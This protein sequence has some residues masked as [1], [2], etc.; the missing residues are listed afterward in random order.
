MIDERIRHSVKAG[1][2]VLL[3]SVDALGV[4]SCC[5]ALA[6]APSDD[7]ATVTTYDHQA[8]S[9]ET[10]A[11]VAA[12]HRLAIVSTNPLDHCSIQLKGTTTGVRL[13]RDDEEAIA[14]EGL[15][16]FAR[17]LEV[18]GVPRRILR[19]VAHWPAFAIEMRVEEIYEQTPGPRAG[20]RLR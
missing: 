2:S 16:R 11:N 15:D 7:F 1:V 6:L 3:G 5:R 19:G 4:P 9:Q 8:A 17:S 10:I 12:T 13:A 14:R 18:I 20:S